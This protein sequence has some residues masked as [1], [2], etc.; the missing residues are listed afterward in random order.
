MYGNVQ[1]R[2][3][4]LNRILRGMHIVSDVAFSICWLLPSSL[5][6]CGM[7]FTSPTFTSIFDNIAFVH[8][9]TFGVSLLE[10]LIHV[11]EQK[12]WIRRSVFALSVYNNSLVDSS[13]GAGGGIV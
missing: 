12:Y 3:E 10:S 11:I 7:A 1:I 2:K 8:G 6:L 13:G 5:K 4:C 9:S